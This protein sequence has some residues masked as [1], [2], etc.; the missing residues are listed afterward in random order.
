M[1][2]RT[3][4]ATARGWTPLGEVVPR[5]LDHVGG[6]ITHVEVSPHDAPARLVVRIQDPTGAMD[7]VFLG[8]RM[9]AGLEPG[10]IVCAA[11]RV[12]ESDDVPIMFNP[13]YELC[14]L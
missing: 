3:D 2:N 5:S 9:I 6:R 1:S 11:G 12:A 13:R 14:Q 4:V 7:L 10:T 8:R